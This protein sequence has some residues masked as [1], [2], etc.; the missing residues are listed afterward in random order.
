M[1]STVVYSLTDLGLAVCAQVLKLAENQISN[2]VNALSHVSPAGG[3]EK[4][5]HIVQV[6]CVSVELL[7]WAV[8]E[9]TGEGVV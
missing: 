3:N 6:I 9:D 5:Y 7:V 4:A 2:G 8:N 1:F